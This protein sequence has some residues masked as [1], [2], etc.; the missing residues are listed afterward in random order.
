MISIAAG[1]VRRL[2]LMEDE[3]R[4]HSRATAALKLTRAPKGG[5]GGEGGGE[6]AAVQHDNPLRA[7]GRDGGGGGGGGAW[8]R[9]C[10]GEEVWF[11]R[12]EEVAWELPAG[13][14]V[15]GEAAAAAAAAATP[16]GWWTRHEDEAGDVWYTRGEETLWELPAGVPVWAAH[17][18][19]EGDPFFV[20]EDTGETQWAAP[21]AA[22][23]VA[24]AP[25]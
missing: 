12:G 23:I 16:P 10:D 8:A 2:E 11:S 3:R 7:A 4:S 15:A 6:G 24:R 20:S 22:V 9:H 14:E 19:E 21:D 5:E 1:I 17:F 13:A 25:P 18:D